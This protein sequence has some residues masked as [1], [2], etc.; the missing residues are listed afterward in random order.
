MAGRKASTPRARASQPSAAT[1]RRRMKLVE[2]KRST[3]LQAALKV[4]SQY[5]LHGTSL[6]RVATEADVSKTNLLY[7]F[8]SKDELYV[9]VLRELLDVWLTPLKTFSVE[10]DPLVA[11]GDYIRVKLEL[12]RDHP[13]ESRLFCME[14]MQ[15]AP[16][17]LAELEQPLRELV[18]AKVKVIKA[19]IDSGKIAPVDPHHLIF[20]IWATTQ[21][22]ADFQTQVKAVTGRTLEDPAFFEEVLQNLQALILNGLRPR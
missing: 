13:E 15:G 16:L 4:F 19:W 12:S 14:V 11:I 18:E 5:G 1:L 20:S 8:G 3:I 10:Q 17:L 6:D 2:S 22:Y 7:Y 21:H 9:S